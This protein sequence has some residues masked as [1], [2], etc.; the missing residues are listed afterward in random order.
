MSLKFL[1][2]FVML[3]VSLES[4]ESSVEISFAFV[5]ASAAAAA[6][7]SSSESAA[8]AEKECQFSIRVQISSLHQNVAQN[9]DLMP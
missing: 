9:G 4:S 1:P 7:K 3:L 5:A 8:C 2:F 6:A